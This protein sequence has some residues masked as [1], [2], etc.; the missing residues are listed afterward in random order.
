[1]I[2]RMIEIFPKFSKPFGVEGSEGLPNLPGLP[3]E[4]FG[5]GEIEV[6]SPVNLL[7]SELVQIKHTGRNF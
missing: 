7:F 6:P 4:N 5:I 3:F 1:M 2:M